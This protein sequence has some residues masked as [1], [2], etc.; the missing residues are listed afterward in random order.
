MSVWAGCCTITIAK[1]LKPRNRLIVIRLRGPQSELRVSFVFALT[2][3]GQHARPTCQ[4]NS[5]TLHGLKF[6]PDRRFDFV[7]I[8]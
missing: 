4:R 7:P 5:T 8:F 3:A 6:R 1:R 2:A